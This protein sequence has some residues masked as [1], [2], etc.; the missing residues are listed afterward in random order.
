[1]LNTI[2]AQIK[3]IPIAIRIYDQIQ[4]QMS[5]KALRKSP[6]DAVSKL[7]KKM[8]GYELDLNNPKTFNEKIQW[9]KLYWHDPI[10]P[11]LVDKFTVRKYV[12]DKI[13]E[14]Y[15][16]PLYSTFNNV[17]DIIFEEL[18]NGC[19]LKPNHGSGQVLIV[20]DKMKIN[21]PKERKAFERSMNNNFYYT[22]YEWAYKDIEPKIICEKLLDDQIIDYKFFCFGGIPEFLYVS[23]GLVQDHTLKVGFY[24]LNWE[25]MPFQRTD[26]EGLDGDLKRPNKLAEMEKLASELSKGF[27][28]VRV[29]LYCVE[30][31]IYFSEMTFTP[32]SGY[33]PL[34][35]D[36]YDV[37]LGE[38]LTLPEKKC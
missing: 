35:P 27:P 21:W 24:D 15:L 13:G 11:T 29:D 7:F 30:D 25:K 9:M 38:L 5:K 14:E 28:F 3:N 1:M 12:A 18:P 10:L 32:S 20:R 31:E 36:S 26:Y 2:R 34:N 4:Y 19:V 37:I 17:D 22:W 16:V 6:E 8:M 23:Q 33:M